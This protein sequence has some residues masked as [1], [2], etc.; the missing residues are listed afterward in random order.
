MALAISRE[1]LALVH[2]CVAPL[3]VLVTLIWVLQGWQPGHYF[4][5]RVVRS[6]SVNF[7]ICDTNIKSQCDFVARGNYWRESVTPLQASA[8]FTALFAGIEGYFYGDSRFTVMPE[9]NGI[10]RSKPIG[11]GGRRLVLIL[12]NYNMTVHH[13]DGEIV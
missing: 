5:K 11:G 12:G 4:R 10:R 9:G 13:R 2:I 6:T 7:R 8:I 3:C 1:S